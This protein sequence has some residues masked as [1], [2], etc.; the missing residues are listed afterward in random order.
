MAISRNLIEL[1][2]GTI[3]LT[4]AGI[5]QGTTVTIALPLIDIALLS[6]PEEK[7]N[8]E[9]IEI[10]TADEVKSEVNGYV[11]LQAE[12]LLEATEIEESPT[13]EIDETKDK[14]P[15][16][17]NTCQLTLLTPQSIFSGRT[18]GETCANGTVV[19]R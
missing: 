15:L 17:E 16:L 11:N 7:E 5:N 18:A 6:P 13:T 3:T 2:K 1:M 4:S 12:P 10:P 8:L 9:D 14:L 19:E